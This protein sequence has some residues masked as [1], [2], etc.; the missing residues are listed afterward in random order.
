PLPGLQAC[1]PSPVSVWTP[2]K[3]TRLP[4]LPIWDA[5][6]Q[7]AAVLRLKRPRRKENSIHPL[8]RQSEPP[9][10]RLHLAVFL[11]REPLL[12]GINDHQ[13]VAAAHAQR[14]TARASAKPGNNLHQTAPL[15]SVHS[16][17]PPLPPPRPPHASPHPHTNPTPHPKKHPQQPEA[18]TSHLHGLT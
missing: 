11:L 8:I 10:P 13:Q 7:R 5:M 14:P 17:P 16:P 9:L 15:R 2:G 1:S 3:D 6:C 4:S 18:P 12:D